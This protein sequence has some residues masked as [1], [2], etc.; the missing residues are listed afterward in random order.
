MRNLLLKNTK[1]VAD[2]VEPPYDYHKNKYIDPF[3]FKNILQASLRIKLLDSLMFFRGLKKMDYIVFITHALK[4]KFSPENMP[5]IIIPAVIFNDS[6]RDNKPFLI[7]QDKPVFLYIGG[8]YPKDAPEKMFAF[9]KAIR[10]IFNDCEIFI[11]GRFKNAES[12]F[13]VNRYK[14]V[15]IKNIF[16]YENLSDNKLLDLIEKANFLVCFRE[17]TILQE[18]TFPTRIVEFLYARKPIISN[19]YGD[20]PYYFTSEKNAILVDINST[21]EGM[22][23]E[24]LKVKK[25]LDE[26]NAYQLVF[27]SK[28]LLKNHFSAT[29]QVNKLIN[30]VN[31]NQ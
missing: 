2:V 21:E 17:E 24:C 5:T 1:L 9:F 30:F 18:Y 26:K 31:Q 25:Y 16:F 12:Q 14:E 27:E 29:M 15:F 19:A 22:I 4:N 11:A 23:Q 7:N 28:K 13:W 3:V 20:I 10:Q 6:Y 8:F